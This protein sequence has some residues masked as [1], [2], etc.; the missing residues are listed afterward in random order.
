MEKIPI[1]LSRDVI[2]KNIKEAAEFVKMHASDLNGEL[3]FRGLCPEA[4]RDY[5]STGHLQP[6]DCELGVGHA[7]CFSNDISTALSLAKKRLVITSRDILDK[8][9]TP[10]D[11]RIPGQDAPFREQLMREKGEGNFNGYDVED[12]M[13]KRNTI[14]PTRNPGVYTYCHRKPLPKKDVLLE[15]VISE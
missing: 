5:Q 7:V 6:Y 3:L 10:I 12:L 8:Y 15:I 13:E 1:K 2:E 14:V 9:D 11:Q 4:E